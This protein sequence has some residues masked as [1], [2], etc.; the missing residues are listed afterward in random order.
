MYKYDS[1]NEL[2]SQF[3]KESDIEARKAESKRIILKYSKHL[4]IIAECLPGDKNMQ[5]VTPNTQYKKRFLVCHDLTLAQFQ[6][7]LR[8]RIGISSS[9]AIT[10]FCKNKDMPTTSDNMLSLYDR[11]VSDDGFLYIFYGSEAVFGTSL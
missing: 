5:T 3:E 10:I 11:Y 8:K 2:V 9:D 7:I 4:P 1:H 6:M